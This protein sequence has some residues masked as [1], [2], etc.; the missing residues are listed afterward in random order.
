MSRDSLNSSKKEM[1]GSA[2]RVDLS[3]LDRHLLLPLGSRDGTV[4]RALP[5]RQCGPG[6]NTRDEFVIGPHPCSE[7]FHHVLWFSSLHK[8]QLCVGSFRKNPCFPHRRSRKIPRGRGGSNG[9]NFHEV[10]GASLFLQN[11]KHSNKC[12]C[13]APANKYLMLQNILH[14]RH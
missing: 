9:R 8:N 11:K 5:S 2:S 7:G 4:V 1:K 14:L 12:T 13:T 6:S 3:S 10:W